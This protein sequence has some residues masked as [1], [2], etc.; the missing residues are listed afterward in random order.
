M[1]TKHSKDTFFRGTLSKYLAYKVRIALRGDCCR[2]SRPLFRVLRHRTP[3]PSICLSEVTE[4]ALRLI[5][6]I[7]LIQRRGKCPS[8]EGKAPS[9]SGFSASTHV[10]LKTRRVNQISTHVDIRATYV[11]QTY[12]PLVHNFYPYAEQQSNIGHFTKLYSF[13]SK[14]IRNQSKAI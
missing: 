1:C 11:A 10:V 13:A 3:S 4:Q 12:L 2:E 9:R 14:A 8:R 7:P 5:A 6:S